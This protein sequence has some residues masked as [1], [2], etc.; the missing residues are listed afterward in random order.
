MA[1]RGFN[2]NIL[3]YMPIFRFANTVFKPRHR[4]LF[5]LHREENAMSMK[6]EVFSDGAVMFMQNAFPIMS[7]ANWKVDFPLPVFHC[8]GIRSRAVLKYF[9]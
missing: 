8:S 5:W 3:G 9:R 6:P 2:L 7:D 1:P 4:L